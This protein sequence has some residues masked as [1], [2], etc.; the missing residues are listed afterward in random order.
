MAD[1]AYYTAKVNGDLKWI[2]MDGSFSWKWL[3]V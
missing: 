1:L 3:S 2:K